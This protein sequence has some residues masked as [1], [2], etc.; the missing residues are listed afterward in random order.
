MSNRQKR[1]EKALEKWE[2][3]AYKNGWTDALVNDLLEDIAGDKYRTSENSDDPIWETIQALDDKEIEE[4]LR[5]CEDIARKEG[6]RLTVLTVF[7]GYDEQG[8]PVFTT[9]QAVR[10]A[11]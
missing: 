4:F 5:G 3:L 9:E 11:N 7:A 6:D 2:A 8:V 1:N 10:E